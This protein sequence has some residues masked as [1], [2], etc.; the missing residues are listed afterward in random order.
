MIVIGVT[1]SVGMGKTEAA[2]RFL[3]NNID[4]FDCDKEIASFYNKKKTISEIKKTFPSSVFK[5]KVDKT[6]LAKIVFGDKKKLKFLE[7]LFQKKLRKTQAFWLRKKIREKKK[8]LVFDV[9]LLFEKDNLRKYDIIIVLS[10]DIEIQRRRVLK[11]KVWTRDRLKKTLKEQM[12]DRE[13]TTL[14]DIII[15]T[16]RGKRDLNKNIIKIIKKARTRRNRRINDILK[17]F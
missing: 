7:S 12:P 16:D 13:K 14:G 9:P 15:K 8:I 17:E 4:V 6:A 10:C 11:R 2:K 1:G 3:R 5:D